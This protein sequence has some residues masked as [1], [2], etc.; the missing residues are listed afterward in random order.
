MHGLTVGG[1][2]NLFVY[3]NEED[4]IEFTNEETSRFKAIIASRAEGEGR[5]G[6]AVD[7][8]DRI[9]SST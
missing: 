2:G 7:S 1:G 9:P 3:Y 5:F 8:S 6:V 4:V